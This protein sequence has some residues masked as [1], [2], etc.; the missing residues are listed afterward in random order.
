MKKLLIIIFILALSTLFS[1]A[2]AQVQQGID[3][4]EIYS[5]PKNPSEMQDVTVSVESYLEDLDSSSIV[6]MVN[7]KTEAHGIGMKE[8]KVVAPKTG[9]ALA[10]IAIIKTSSG[11][12]IRKSVV[13]KSGSVDIV[14][15]S[16]GYVPPFYKGRNFFTYQNWI[17]LVAVPHLSIDGVKEVNPK[18]LVYVWKKGGKYIEGGKGYGKQSVDIKADD[19]PKTLEITVEV[20][21]KD[22]SQLATGSLNINPTEPSVLLYEVSPLYGS[23]FNK[24]LTG[25]I[26][27]EGS[28]LSVLAA[29]F[30]FNYNAK[31]NQLKYNWSINNVEQPNLINNQ[32]IVLKTTGDADGSSDVSVDIRSEAEL[33]QGARSFVNV[34]FKKALVDENNV[35]F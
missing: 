11:K 20:Y 34:N 7:G 25:R 6:W 13:I 35:T 18:D 15:E 1:Y 23:L 27:L 29:P 10:V 26:T 4:V 24:A 21:T 28:E 30:G 8:L 5:N 33:L 9:K 14:F 2:N 19:I 22:Q 12:E 31:A 3:G 17:R 32:S 16:K